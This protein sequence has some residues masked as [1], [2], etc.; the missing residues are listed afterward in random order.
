L[1]ENVTPSAKSHFGTRHRAGLGITEQTD[2]V[3]IVVSEET[4]AISV[5]RNGKLTRDL[6]PDELKKLL[7]SVYT[8]DP[9]NVQRLTRLG[10]IG[11]SKLFKK[12]SGN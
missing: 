3:V 1:S 9:I 11:V 10:G 2:A 12:R 5:A 4:G 8:M 7:V 6:D